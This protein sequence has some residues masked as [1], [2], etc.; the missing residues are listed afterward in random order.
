MRGEHAARAIYGHALVSDKGNGEDRQT[1]R[2][3]R[4][5]EG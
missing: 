5:A 4:S 3:R 1:A 2:G